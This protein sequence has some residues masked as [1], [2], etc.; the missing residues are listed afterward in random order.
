MPS[1][2]PHF[3]V[4]P[5]VH[6]LCLTLALISQLVSMVSQE[7]GGVP[8]QLMLG[9]DLTRVQALKHVRAEYDS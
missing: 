8:D 6:M 4:A 2:G 1:V 3:L 9:Q 5:G 7:A